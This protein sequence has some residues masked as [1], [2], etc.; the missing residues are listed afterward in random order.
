MTGHLVRTP[1][2]TTSLTADQREKFIQFI[3][4]DILFDCLMDATFDYD[5]SRKMSK[6]ICGACGTKSVNDLLLLVRCRQF[7]KKAN[8]DIHG[9]DLTL[10][11]GNFEIDRI[12][13]LYSGSM[14]LLS[15]W[16]FVSCDSLRAPSRK[17]LGYGKSIF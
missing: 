5:R 3:Y 4:E 10:S 8:R 7:S 14:R 6:T 15:V 2:D 12:D 13:V 9:R 17:V 11:T 16:K 1:I